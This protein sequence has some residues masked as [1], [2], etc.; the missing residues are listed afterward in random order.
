MH[1]HTNRR[2]H[3]AIS[4]YSCCRLQISGVA[5]AAP[6]S[7]SSLGPRGKTCPRASASPNHV[8]HANGRN[9]QPAV[10]SAE[11]YQPTAAQNATTRPT[12]HRDTKKPNRARP[13]SWSHRMAHIQE[14]MNKVQ[15]QLQQHAGL[16]DHLPDLAAQLKQKGEQHLDLLMQ[17]AEAEQK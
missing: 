9:K 13:S 5:T 2:G 16:Q 7:S 6:V 15:E 11:R 12:S 10:P 8:P 17:L 14:L 3:R 4:Q 1:I